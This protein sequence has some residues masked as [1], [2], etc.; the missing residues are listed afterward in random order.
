MTR[1]RMFHR[2]VSKGAKK[3]PAIR[4]TFRG[5]NQLDYFALRKIAE[6]EDG[7]NTTQTNLARMIISDW[8]RD[9]EA[10]D[11]KKKEVLVRQLGLNLMDVNKHAK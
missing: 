2:P 1:K 4:I 5:V 3:L 8:V 11:T 7:F 10:K 9:W 6:K